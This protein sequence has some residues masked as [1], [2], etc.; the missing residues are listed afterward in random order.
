VIPCLNEAAVIESVISRMFEDEGL[1]DPI[2][3]V[4]DGGST[5]GTLD[6]VAEIARRDPRVRLIHNPGRLQSKGLNL[7]ARMMG[8]DDRPWLV[9]V[10]AHAEYPK[11]YASSL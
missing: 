7:V 9:R 6:I 8:D 1:A 2:V 4:A 3:V 11:N 5:D 10:D